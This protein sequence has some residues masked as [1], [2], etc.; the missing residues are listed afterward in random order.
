MKHSLAKAGLFSWLAAFATAA[1][2]GDMCHH[3]RH[4]SPLRL[5]E[6]HPDHVSIWWHHVGRPPA[7]SLGSGPRV[8]APC[9]HFVAEQAIVRDVE[10]R[11]AEPGL[12]W[13]DRFRN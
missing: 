4:R 7:V 11:S 5:E 6:H 12:V 13:V 3:K 1:E 8:K 9:V 10:A 2:S